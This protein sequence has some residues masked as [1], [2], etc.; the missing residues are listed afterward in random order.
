MK[1]SWLTIF[2]FGIGIGAAGQHFSGPM[3]YTDAGQIMD[4]TRELPTHHCL[5]ESPF[6]Y[7][8]TS[9]FHITRSGYSL[10]YDASKRN[11]AWVYEH[12]TAESIQGDAERSFEF[13]D[14]PNIPTYLRATSAD[15]KGQGFDRGHMAPAADHRSSSKA[16]AD[17]F[18]MTNVCPQ[19]PQLNRGYWS[20]LEKHVRNLTKQYANVHVVTGPLYL[21]YT[22]GDGKRYVKYQVIGKNDV[23]IPTH[24]LP[25]RLQLLPVAAPQRDVRASFPAYG[26]RLSKATFR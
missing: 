16:M 12:L 1:S 6:P 13:K 15:C 4:S 24:F 8:P 20:K 26:S 14:D 17:T 7:Q 2:C 19:C 25:S 22:D 9:S 11:P 18:Y 10:A 21:P 23:A 3:L 5:Q